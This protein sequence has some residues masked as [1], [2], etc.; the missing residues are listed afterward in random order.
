M[1]GIHLLCSISATVWARTFFNYSDSLLSWASGA[2]AQGVYRSQACLL[3][4]WLCCAER[5]LWAKGAIAI[6]GFSYLWALSKL[7]FQDPLMPNERDCIELVIPIAF[8][9]ML[10]GAKT[11][12]VRLTR[13][14]HSGPSTDGGSVRI[15]IRGY[16]LIVFLFGVWLWL[17]VVARAARHSPALLVSAMIVDA[18][19]VSVAIAALWAMLRVQSVVIGLCWITAITVLFVASNYG[20]ASSFV[21]QPFLMTCLQV[22]AHAVVMVSSA[23]ALRRCGYR[24]VAPP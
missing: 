20:I 9:V 6:A 23:Y 2:S 11:L 14:G 3:G 1:F 17:F 19:C 5:S 7:G 21:P 15:S 16:M 4:L 13:T 22:I 18:P 8:T 12:G 10:L 24:L